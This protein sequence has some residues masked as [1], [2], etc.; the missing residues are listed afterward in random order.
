MN[1]DLNNMAKRYKDEMMRLYHQSGASGKKQQSSG[2]MGMGSGMSGNA[3]NAQMSKSATDRM[4]VQA[5]DY[6]AANG[7]QTASNMQRNAAGTP[8]PNVPGASFYNSSGMDQNMSAQN[9]SNGN[10]DNIDSNMQVT[11]CSGGSVTVP[12]NVPVECECRFPTA[13]SIIDSINSGNALVDPLAGQSNMNRPALY[14]SNA[15][16]NGMNTMNTMTDTANMANMTR[17]AQT[18]SAADPVSVQSLSAQNMNAQSL[19]NDL[20]SILSSF[21]INAFPTNVDYT[22]N[23]Q[24]ENT[25]E[26]LPDFALPADLPAEAEGEVPQ[27]RHFSPSVGWIT[28]TGDNSWG[29]FQA[30][31]FD[32]NGDPIQ[33]ALVIVRKLVNNSERLTRL[34]F[35]NRNG[36]T[37]TIALPAP[38]SV[39]TGWNSTTPFS[40]YEITVRAQGYYTMRNIQIA[41]YAGSKIR[42]PIEMTRI[43]Q[44][45]RPIQ[46]RSNDSVG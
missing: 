35:T 15:A 31:V 21:I 14:N 1:N 38:L 7:G 13:E 23:D 40:T 41:M 2:I 4:A 11:G 34:L 32:A 43:Y 17:S 12:I 36:F 46:P 44:N 3:V 5:Q 30:E 45:N 26:V 42:Q 18:M 9:G 20:G 29:F 19:S 6:A 39:N 10:M 22:A 25:R 16:A 37:P 27:T 8:V 33:G 28:I 24:N